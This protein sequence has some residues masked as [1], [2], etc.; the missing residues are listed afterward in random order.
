MGPRRATGSLALVGGGEWGPG[1]REFD[2]ELLARSGA[3]RGAGAPDRGRVRA[4]GTGGGA[5]RRRT[6]PSSGATVRTLPV[7]H[8]T[9][10]EDP[11]IAAAGARRPKFVYLADGSPLHLRSVLKG[12][13]LFDALLAAVPRRAGCWRRR[14]RA[15]RCCAIPM[16]DP[17]G[18]AYTV[19]LGVVKNLA[20]FPYHG[21]AADHLRERSVD[22][23]PT[24]AR[25]SRASTRRPRSIKRCR[26][27]DRRR[28]RARSRSTASTATPTLHRRR[29]G[30]RASPP[31]VL[32]ADVAARGSASRRAARP[33]RAGSRA[34][35]RASSSPSRMCSSSSRV[36]LSPSSRQRAMPRL[37]RSIDSYSRSSASCS[38]SGTRLADAH[39]AEPLQVGDA[40]EE[41]DAA[42]QRVGVLHLV[43]RLL[44]VVLRERLVAPVVEH[45]VVDEVLVDRGELGGEDLVEQFGDLGSRAHAREAT[46]ARRPIH[47]ERCSSEWWRAAPRAPASSRRTRRPRRSGRSA[48]RRWCAPRATSSSITRS[49]TARQWHTYTPQG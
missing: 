45:L 25:C 34:S 47:G 10:A 3:E 17:R 39:R 23:L 49:V 48:P 22:L 19:G 35:R 5:G 29:R 28:G 41:Q 31:D 14:A 46:A 42:D 12:S 1:A 4:P 27:V 43:D 20:V 44:A 30:R 11:D 8:R 38:F 7:L 2:A 16:V 15:P 36:P 37:S 9:E 33:G 18:G 24:A 13:V 21:T 6:S 26:R 40:L 32:A